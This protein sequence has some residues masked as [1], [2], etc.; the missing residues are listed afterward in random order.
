[1]MH[2]IHFPHSL[3]GR[4]CLAIL[5]VCFALVE[6][7]AQ[8]LPEIFNTLLQRDTAFTELQCK[9]GIQVQL[10]GLSMPDKTVSVVMHKNEDIRIEGDGL[11]LIPRRGLVGQYQAILETPCQA[12][13]LQETPD[14]LIYKLV[15]LDPE[16]DWVTVDFTLSASN[17][18][19]HQMDVVTRENGTFHIHHDY[20][21][22]TNSFP[23]KTTIS[24]EALPMKL[25]L[26]FIAQNDETNQLFNGDEP[27][28]GKVILTYSDVVVK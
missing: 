22:E 18:L 23:A 1:M 8:Q 14:T 28:A 19:V 24:F 15:S 26:R 4:H 16:S 20:A 2:L 21:G 9:I 17:A 3:K 10:P 12:I 13:P 27:I 5:L 7:K 25:P 6:V 11:M